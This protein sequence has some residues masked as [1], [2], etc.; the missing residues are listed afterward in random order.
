MHALLVQHQQSAFFQHMIWYGPRSEKVQMHRRQ[1]NWLKYTDC[2][3]L[4]KITVKIYWN[5]SIYSS[6]FFKS[7]KFCCCSF[8]LIKKNL[9]L[10]VQVS[11][12]FY[13]LLSRFFNGKVVFLVGF[14]VFKVVFLK[15][16]VI[17]LCRFFCNNPGL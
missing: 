6:L 10:T 3:E 4:K 11:C 16:T 1:K 17:F 15:K 5:C 14:T 7:I 8:C 9:Q 2:A 12:L 13:F